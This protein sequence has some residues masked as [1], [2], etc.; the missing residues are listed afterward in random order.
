MP[1]SLLAAKPTISVPTENFRSAPSG[2][3][4][5]VLNHGAELKILQ[6]QDGWVKVSVEGW[7]LKK[8]IKM[9][10][11]QK[12]TLEWKIANGTYEWS[13]R[14]YDILYKRAGRHQALKDAILYLN[15]ANKGDSKMYFA[16][17][18]ALDPGYSVSSAVSGIEILRQVKKVNQPEVKDN[19]AYWVA[20]KIALEGAKSPRYRVVFDD[21]VM[22]PEDENV[23]EFVQAIKTT[24]SNR[25]ILYDRGKRI[26]EMDKF[27]MEHKV[28]LKSAEA[29]DY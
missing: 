20:L 11:I 8:T 3:I 1:T 17:S 12:G 27:V 21:E 26:L 15:K 29:S 18:L 5:G 2:P 23:Y 4:L 13:H 24:R 9:P 14:L 28:I 25:L 6:E 16:A 22:R 7:V 10:E 19:P